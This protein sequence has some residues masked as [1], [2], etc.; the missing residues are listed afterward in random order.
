VAFQKGLET[1]V[2]VVNFVPE[3]FF[4][5]K[6]FPLPPDVTSFL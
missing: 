5:T 2:D 3:R 6:V 1:G 4:L